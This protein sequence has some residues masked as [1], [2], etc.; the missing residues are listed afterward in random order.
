MPTRFIGWACDVTGVTPIHRFDDEAVLAEAGATAGFL[1]VGAP[2]VALA[3]AA[4]PDTERRSISEQV[5]N[6][7]MGMIKSG[8]LKSGD[9]LPTEAQMTIAF[10]ISR[11]PLREALKALTIM[12]V[13][14]SRQGGR[15]TVTDLSPA[16]LV[17]P[18]NAML[19]VAAFD[20][21]QQFEARTLIDCELVRLCTLRADPDLRHRILKLAVDGDAFKDDPVGFRLMDIEFHQAL[22]LGAN[23]P[24]LKTVSQGLY[25]LALDFRRAASTIPGNIAISVRQHVAVAEAVMARDPDR[26]A[27]AFRQHLEH[28]R[29]S[30]LQSM[31]QF[32]LK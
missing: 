2:P 25:D 9:R 4:K 14:E 8:N 22:N 28:V 26:A 18:F 12:G 19:S 27:E 1:L 17:A 32:S 15:Y 31:T 7:I 21:N 29:D 11:P 6:Q 3:Q 16:R 13:L 10:G 30:T 20:V 23:N 24:L 5:A